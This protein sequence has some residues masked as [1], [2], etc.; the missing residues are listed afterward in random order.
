MKINELEKLLGISKANIRYYESEG[1]ITPKRTE[2]GYRSYTDYDARLLKKI[3]VYRKLGIAIS[4]IKAVIN[5]ERSLND[6]LIDSIDSMQKNINNQAIAIEICSEIVDKGITDIDFDTDY[7]WNE[8]ENRELDGEEFIDVGNIDITP[9]KNRK[10][11]KAL[12]IAFVVLFFAGIIYSFLCSY[13]FVADDNENYKSTVPQVNT[14]DTIDTVKL[15][16]KNEL[17][18]VCYNRGT[19]VNTYDFNGNFKWAVSVPTIKSRGYTY[20]YLKENKLYIDNENEVYIYN[21]V[22]GEYIEKAFAD[23]LGLVA[24]RDNFDKYHSEDIEAAK[25]QGITFDAYNAYIT[26]EDGSRSAFVEK[27]LYV[28]LQS[29][30]FG[31]VIA[32]ISAIALAVI[33]FISRVKAIGAIKLNEEE[34]SKK[35]KAHRIFNLTLMAVYML[36]SIINIVTVIF[37]LVRVSLVIF[38]ATA[39][40]IVALV[41]NDATKNRYNK[42][43]HKYT[44]TA[45]NYLIASYVVLLISTII[46][47]MF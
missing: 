10:R 16:E 3:I 20:F 24:E 8:I 27:P 13:A 30:N 11:V 1:L 41:V 39:L 35:A 21:C 34:I 31:F 6:V 33:A 46:S 12:I 29:D 40:F 37:S 43:E 25:A 18:Y 7:F 32:F 14:A 22:T 23:E 44:A 9:F 4:G 15:D 36:F 28:M 26:A 5:N 2:N 45:L 42:S 17:I 47:I 38:P 19:C